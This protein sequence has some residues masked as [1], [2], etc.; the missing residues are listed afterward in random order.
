MLQIT[1]PAQEYFLELLSKREKN[2]FIKILVFF[3]KNI[4]KGKMIFCNIKTIKHNDIKLNFNKLKIFIEKNSLKFLENV[5]IDI[6]SNNLSKK[7]SFTVLNKNIKNINNLK[8]N[9]NIFLKN[10]INP[11]LFNHGGS[12]T[13]KNITTNNILLLEF[14]GGCQ[15]CMMSKQTLQNWIAKEILYNFPDIKDVYDITHHKKNKFSYY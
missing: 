3:K 12:I 9:V 11:K 1:K 10:V 5:K 4:L 13:L 14:H 7:V 8:K 15:G 6:I 2:T